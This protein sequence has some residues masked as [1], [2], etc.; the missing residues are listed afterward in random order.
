MLL[1]EAPRSHQ[2]EI[3]KSHEAIKYNS[4]HTT[5]DDCSKAL[6][7]NVSPIIYGWAYSGTQLSALKELKTIE[8]HSDKMSFLLK[9]SILYIIYI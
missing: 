7:S 9:N 1:Q 4:T 6:Y 5:D 2:H 3:Q 8:W